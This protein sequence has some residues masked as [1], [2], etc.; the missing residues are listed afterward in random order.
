[1]DLHAT[2]SAAALSRS[3]V[4]AHKIRVDRFSIDAFRIPLK[5]RHDG[6]MV[7][8]NRQAHSGDIATRERVADVF[9]MILIVRGQ[10]VGSLGMSHKSDLR[11][12][13]PFQARIELLLPCANTRIPPFT[14]CCCCVE[15]A[16]SLFC[17]GIT[18]AFYPVGHGKVI[19]RFMFFARHCIH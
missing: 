6:P 14:R 4:T 5:V 12:I 8:G 17:S 10:F 7:V 15:D 19:R 13:P 9:G 2:S 18:L 1:M 3:S 16:I 11:T